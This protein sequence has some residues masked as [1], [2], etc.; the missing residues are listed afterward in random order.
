[1]GTKLRTRE[2]NV[3]GG[4]VAIGGA[5]DHPPATGVDGVDVPVVK[6][7]VRVLQLHLDGH[8][9]YHCGTATERQVQVSPNS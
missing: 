9:S 3:Q 6:R 7:V 2:H 1:M 4:D 8:Q 5:G